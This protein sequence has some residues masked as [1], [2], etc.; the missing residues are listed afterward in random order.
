M[1]LG[2][3]VGYHV[4]PVPGTDP[5]A[6]GPGLR[7][8]PS[9]TSAATRW[10]A[11]PPRARSGTPRRR[12]VQGLHHRH[13]ELVLTTEAGGGEPVEF[14][15]E[16]AANPIPPWHLGRLAPAPARLRGYAAVHPRDGRAGGRRPVRRGA[17]PRHAGPRSSWPHC[18]PDRSEEITPGAG[19]GTGA[20]ST[21]RTSPP[22]SPRPGPR[23]LRSSTGPRPPPTRSS[24][25]VTPTST[26]PGCGR[27]ARPSANAHGP[28]PTSSACSSATPSTTSSCS[29][30]VQYQWMKD[31]YPELYRSRSWN[32]SERAGGSRSAGMWVEPDTNV[33]SGESLVRQLVYGKRFF[34][35]EFGVETHE[36]W[37]PDVFG[38]SA[39]LP[40]IAR[41]GRRHLTHHPEDAAGTTPTPFRTPPSGGRATTAAACWPT[42]PRPTP[43]T[44]TSPRRGRRRPGP[45]HRARTARHSTSTP[46]GTATAGVARTPPWSSASAAW[47]ISMA[48]PG[49][50]SA[51]S[52]AF[53]DRGAREAGD[54]PAWVGELYL[55]SPP[56][57]PD[58][59]RRR[60][61]G[62]PPRRGSPPG[63]RAV[64]GGRVPRPAS[65]PRAG[66][67]APPPPPVPRHPPRLQHPLGLRGRRREHAEV[68]ADRAAAVIAEAQAA[69][70]AGGDGTGGAAAWWPSTRRPTDRTE[71][72]ELP[73]G[74]LAVV[75]APA[76]GWSTGAARPA[77]VA[78][79]SR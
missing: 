78:A 4:V 9:S 31:G 14:F 62:Q 16:A 51:R 42:S 65:R 73:D 44:A 76:C 53:L 5:R 56:G 79:T 70:L 8:W 21:P 46:T 58:H 24:R 20:S 40:Q 64:V 74:S 50:R 33:P 63:R 38:Y 57:H 18:G 77:P 49:W 37:I 35:E 23:W 26:A 48:C 54:L 41:A 61:A 32:R 2:R 72:V 75:S 29:Q 7:W 12:P 60:Q 34:A 69:P 55:E 59:P 28:S 36:L 52:A 1:T 25:W 67:E 22:R 19:Q 11:S 10:S 71:V 15:V 6:R 66:L 47:P 3:H 68:L 17:L 45:R 27:S 13:R 39:A 30:A 43:T